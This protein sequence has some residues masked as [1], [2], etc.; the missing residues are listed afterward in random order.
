MNFKY[1]TLEEAKNNRIT[2][3]RDVIKYIQKYAKLKQEVFGVIT[4]DSNNIITSVNVLFKGGVNTAPVDKKILFPYLCKK[5]AVAFVI[6]HNHP[7][8]D[9]IPSEDDIKTT[10]AIKDGA[11]LLGIELLDHIIIGQYNYYSF[12]EYGEFDKKYKVAEA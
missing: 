5:D 9:T 3:P 8:G 10:N 11:D 2:S 12:L 4:T 7:S 6:F 1:K